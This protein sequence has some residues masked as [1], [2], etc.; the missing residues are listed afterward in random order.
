MNDKPTVLYIAGSGRSGSTVLSRLL[1][2]VDGVFA[3]G[4]VRYLWE[5]GYL[6]N[7][8]CACGLEFD[9]CECWQAIVRR[10]FGAVDRDAA[11]EL[12]GRIDGATRMR[13]LP[14]LLAQ[15]ARRRPWENGDLP[16]RLAELYRAMLRE[17]G[18]RVVLDSSKLP[19]YAAL[20]GSSAEV[21][22]RVLHLVRDPRAAAYSWM[23][24]VARHAATGE[25]MDR[26]PAWKAAALWHVWNS[27][28]LRLWGGDPTCYLRV[29][30]EDFVREPEP[31]A[32]AILR[33][34]GLE[35]AALPFV[36]RCQAAV[37]ATHMVAGNPN[38][39][40]A[41]NLTLTEDD[42]WKHQMRPSDKALVVALTEPLLRRFGYPVRD[43]EAA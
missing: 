18:A 26:F 11:A 14:G 30:Y 37:Q 42:E 23:Q 38:R 9:D 20:V 34:A 31:T 22:L 27:T 3:A 21:D 17:T 24:S 41:G 15:G 7:G 2:S 25:A 8:R 29:R 35:G 39:L 33:F 10:A 12:R 43:R 28:A 5:R 32:A 4:E 1:G 13:Q 16:D 40:Q 19:T 36:D 6:Q